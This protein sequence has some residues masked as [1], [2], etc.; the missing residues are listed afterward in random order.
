MDGCTVHVTLRVCAALEAAVAR[1]FGP[2]GL[3]QLVVTA[4]TQLTVTNSGSAILQRLSIAHS[5][6]AFVQA[7]VQVCV[8]QW[9]TVAVSCTLVRTEAC[10]SVGLER[11]ACT[12]S[13]Q[14]TTN[15]TSAEGAPNSARCAPR[16]THWGWG[17]PVRVTFQEV[18]LQCVLDRG[19]RS[20]APIH[21]LCA[22]GA[23]PSAC[24]FDDGGGF[25]LRR[26]AQ[27][28]GTHYGDHST[29]MVIMVTA[30]LRQVCA[31]LRLHLQVHP[32]CVSDTRLQTPPM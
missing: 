31:P 9:P 2:M 30:A 29:A 28:H 11:L 32:T 13:S 8:S 23:R 27:S 14:A 5:V 7:A 26:R 17:F 18:H 20:A 15:F 1:S 16:Q 10:L 6:G 4:G 3:E 25:W 21:P 19:P 24:E 12:Q 22:R